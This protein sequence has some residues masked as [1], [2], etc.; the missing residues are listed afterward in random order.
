MYCIAKK[1]VTQLGMSEVLGPRS[2]GTGHGEVF[3]G[4]DFSSSQDYSDQTATMIDSEIHS[5]I[6]EAYTRAKSILTEYSEKLNFISEFLLKNEIMD[7]EQFEAAMS[8]EPTFEELEEMTEAKKRRSREENEEKRRQEAIAER[9][10]REEEEERMRQAQNPM[11]DFSVKVD[12]PEQEATEDVESNSENTE[13]A[14]PEE[15]TQ[16]SNEEATS[17]ETDSDK[18]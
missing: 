18:Q 5:I 9:K 6:D 1:M 16:E 4:R 3:L 2:F 12:E 7:G 15:D 17:N 13:T 14:L 10:R 11:A 8:G